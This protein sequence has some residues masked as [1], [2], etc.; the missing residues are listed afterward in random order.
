MLLIGDGG[1][2]R[3]SLTKLAA[4]L[5][6]ISVHEI[7]TNS[8]LAFWNFIKSIFESVVFKPNNFLLLFNESDIGSPEVMEEINALLSVGEIPNLYIKR[9]GKDEF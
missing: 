9:E 5:N 1:T 8:N 3:H 4:Y 2:G 6:N 7:R